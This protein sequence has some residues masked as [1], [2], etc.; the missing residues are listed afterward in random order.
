MH[1]AACELEESLAGTGLGVQEL[2]KCAKLQP[3]LVSDGTEE[4]GLNI[5]TIRRV[6]N[7]ALR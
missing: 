1:L 2:A 5:L 6:L 7:C 3:A 4:H